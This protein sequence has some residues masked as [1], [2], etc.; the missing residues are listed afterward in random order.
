MDVK[1]QKDLLFQ[2]AE[3]LEFL[4]KRGICHGD[5]R[6]ENILL[7]LP[8]LGD[9]GEEEMRRLLG[10]SESEP[11]R[12]FK[13][14]DSFSAPKRLFQ[15]RHMRVKPISQIAITDFGI[16]FETT[17]PP[18]SSLLP[19]HY[20]CPEAWLDLDVGP[21]VDVWA[22]VCTILRVRTGNYPFGGGD[23][24]TMALS[25]ESVL[26]PMPEP[27]NSVC[28]KRTLEEAN[29]SIGNSGI[30]G[31]ADKGVPVYLDWKE[32]M[33]I[34]LEDTGYDEPFD[35]LAGEEKNFWLHPKDSQGFPDT[36][37]EEVEVK[38]KVPESEV[39]VLADLIRRSFR[40]HA[41]E[42]LDLA[43]VMSH[44]WFDGRKTK[45]TVGETGEARVSTALRWFG[46]RT[47]A[48]WSS[49]LFYAI[50]VGIWYWTW[51]TRYDHVALRIRSSQNSTAIL[52]CAM[53]P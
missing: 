4:H 18:D 44:E 47:R 9:I 41:F 28:K 32:C 46:S 13:Q 33:A 20:A 15:P 38:Y 23:Y 42:R 31:V 52:V 24:L 49:I 12:P 53:V 8:D 45:K 5:F 29:K 22:F 21:T 19:K 17:K 26:G 48:S 11:V 16:A 27:F 30:G 25:L 34:E 39:P 40:Y 6:T 3:G 43:G 37:Q 50:L 7:R 2:A 1:I 35:A 51:A 36:S 10:P 14:I